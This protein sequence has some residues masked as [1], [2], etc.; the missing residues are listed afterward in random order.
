MITRHLRPS[1]EGT[2]RICHRNLS[3]F[4]R[5]NGSSPR[6]CRPSSYRFISC[7]SLQSR[8]GRQLWIRFFQ[9]VSGPRLYRT[10][11]LTLR[12]G[13]LRPLFLR[14][15][16]A[17]QG[18]GCWGVCL[19]QLWYIRWEGWLR[20]LDFMVD[21]L[22]PHRCQLRHA[23]GIHCSQDEFHDGRARQQHF[24]RDDRMEWFT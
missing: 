9:W 4:W 7:A 17:R 21:G 2:Y 18:Y 6:G 3:C 13:W 23:R 10:R 14:W 22:L 16:W 19:L 15:F 1:W 11:R 12:F 24:M 8:S 20:W 5:S